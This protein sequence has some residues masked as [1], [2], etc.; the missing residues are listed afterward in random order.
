MYVSMYHMS[1]QSFVVSYSDG[2]FEG[3][4]HNIGVFTTE[5][6][7]RNAIDVHN[8]E[9]MLPFIRQYHIEVFNHNEI[10]GTKL[11]TCLLC[12][13]RLN[14]C[15]QTLKLMTRDRNTAQQTV[16][17]RTE[18]FRNSLLSLKE[19]LNVNKDT[20]DCIYELCR[21][22]IDMYTGLTRGAEDVCRSALVKTLNYALRSNNM[23]E[24][25][26]KRIRRIVEGN[27]RPIFDTK[28]AGR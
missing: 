2:S 17:I 6:A 19:N 13:E 11:H 26:K 28:L 12:T 9:P 14:E 7:A 15:M 3:C 24:T 10:I 16:A 22:S 4:L 23:D 1:L 5:K 8:K 25:N 21:S 27:I 18:K 20:S